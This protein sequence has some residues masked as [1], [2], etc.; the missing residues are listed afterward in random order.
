MRCSSENPSTR[1]R[2]SSWGNREKIRSG[3]A[4]ESFL[5]GKSAYLAPDLLPRHG[6]LEVSGLGQ[7][8]CR[9]SPSRGKCC[10]TCL[11]PGDLTRTRTLA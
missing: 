1:G 11:P 10:S 3:E 4:I 9:G 5:S 6:S 8:R 2:S 7:R